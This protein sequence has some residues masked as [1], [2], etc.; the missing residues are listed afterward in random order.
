MERD[1]QNVDTEKFRKI[2][3]EHEGKV[4]A[5]FYANWCTPCRDYAP[6]FEKAAALNPEIIFLNVNGELEP[7]LNQEFNIRGIPCTILFNEGRE[8]KR[9]TGFMSAE[10]VAK[11]LSI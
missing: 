3:R 2:L 7:A 4:L 1:V 6:E 11:F 8:V 10:Q 5:K 9:H